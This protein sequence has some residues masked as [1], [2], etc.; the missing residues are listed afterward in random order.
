MKR[1]N[2]ITTIF[3]VFSVAVF[4]VFTACEPADP[5]CDG[6]LEQEPFECWYRTT[7]HNYVTGWDCGNKNC[8]PTGNGDEIECTC[9]SGCE[10]DM[11]PHPENPADG[12]DNLFACFF[13]NTDFGDRDVCYRGPEENFHPFIYECLCYAGY[14][15]WRECEGKYTED[16][17]MVCMVDGKETECQERPAEYDPG[18]VV[19][20]RWGVAPV[21]WPLPDGA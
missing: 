18:R 2:L 15:C 11:E 17:R 20:C 16:G 5:S 13:G 12:L 14:F 6:G 4:S 1:V 8:T 3:V 9:N 21:E 7:N 19:I 10:C